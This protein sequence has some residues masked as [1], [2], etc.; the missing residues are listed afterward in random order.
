MEAVV[1]R[2]KKA[3]FTIF[4]ARCKGQRSYKEVWQEMEKELEDEYGIGVY[5]DYETF[6]KAKNRYKN[7]TARS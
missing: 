4:Y 2:D 3:Y 7:S 1:L 5:E 6:I